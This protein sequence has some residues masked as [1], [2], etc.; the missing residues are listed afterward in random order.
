[1]ALTNSPVAK[2]D[3]M[4]AA[5]ILRASD[6]EKF[7][8]V[9]KEYTGEALPDLAG[10]EEILECELKLKHYLEARLA[11]SGGEKVLNEIELPTVPVLSDMERR[12]VRVDVDELK[13]QS[14]LLTKDI[15]V[16]EKKIHQ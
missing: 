14:E 6:C 12:G 10:V 11:E 8:D 2:W 9:F 4:L 7:A 15:A 5:Y 13:K 1:L 16:L 3:T